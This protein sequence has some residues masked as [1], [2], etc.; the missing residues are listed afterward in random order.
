MDYSTSDLM[1]RMPEGTGLTER[2]RRRLMKKEQAGMGLLDSEVRAL[3]NDAA[4]RGFVADQI[5]GP[6]MGLMGEMTGVPAIMRGAQNIG[7]GYAEGDVMRGLGGAGEMAMGAMPGAAAFKGGRTA[8]GAMYATAPRA[9]ATGAALTLPMAYTESAEAAKAKQAA[10]PPP[11]PPVV[12]NDPLSD[13]VRGNPALEARHRLLLQKEADAKAPIQ[14]VNRASSDAI[15]QKAAEEATQIRNELMAAIERANADKRAADTAEANKN[16]S[17]REVYAEYMPYA[18]AA[19]VIIGGAGGSLIK[20][21]YSRAFNQKAGNISDSWRRAV[22]SGDKAGATTAQAEMQ[23]LQAKGPGGTLPAIGFGAAVG[24]ETSLLPEELDMARAQPGS[25]LAKNVWDRLTDAPGMAK[26]VG[27]G[28]VSGAAPAF[29]GAELTG[30]L[31]KRAPKTYGPETAGLTAKYTPAGTEDLNALMRYQSAEQQGKANLALQDVKN[32]GLL[33]VA[34]EDAAG[35]L[36]QRQRAN[37][38]AAA[39]QRLDVGAPPP[40]GASAGLMAEPAAQTG[41][42][43]APSRLQPAPVSSGNPALPAPSK[44]PRD[45]ANIWSDP[46]REVVSDYIK[47]NPHAPLSSLTAPDL[48]A[49]IQA[50]LPPGSPLPAASTARGYLRDLR[51]TTGD[52][53]SLAKIKK[54]FASDPSRSLFALPIAAGG[55]GLLSGSDQ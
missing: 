7:R 28:A 53:A 15:R 9:A 8:L 36:S 5:A 18:A 6:A 39:A 33:S 22:E 38:T 24:A 47:K 13:L 4:R 48:I 37:Q 52:R 55:L 25:E 27:L 20:G 43:P 1:A 34:K 54:T 19:P 30:A 10:E 11:Q 41:L 32:Q 23:A 50:R 46:A 44:D 17:V 42:V 16:K 45:W 21:M 49:G 31:M 29:G 40:V 35:L 3:E 51:E 12:P 26:R 14:G 2:E